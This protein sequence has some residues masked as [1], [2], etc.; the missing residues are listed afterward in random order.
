[1]TKCFLGLKIKSAILLAFSFLLSACNLSNDE[2]VTKNIEYTA[3]SA[4]VFESIAQA[5]QSSHRSEANI[6][7]NVY[8]HPEQTLDFFGLKADM[9]VIEI[10][11]GTLWYTEILAPF[12]KQQG[13]LIAAAYDADL[14][15][16]PPYQ[17]RLTHQMIHRFE[18]QALVFGGVEVVKFTPPKSMALGDDGVA[19]MVLTF[20]NSHGWVND[21][22]AEQAYQSFY[23]VLKPG[24]VLGVVQ[25]RGDNRLLPSGKLSGYL[26]EDVVIAAAVAAGFVLEAKSEINANPKDTKDY[27]MGVWTLPPV[28]RAKEVQREKYIAIGESD[29]MT[30]KFR[31]PLLML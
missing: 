21:G 19:D 30:L 15:G 24:G 28:L 22:S 5:A 13:R 25:H 10:S 6:L 20:R 31:K 27:E 12:L 8:R 11:P 3:P 23:K 1:M 17:A 9:T 18:N 29:R 26:S 7:R 2:S 14:A 4:D 16:Q